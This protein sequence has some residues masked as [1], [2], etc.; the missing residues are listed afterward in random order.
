MFSRPANQCS[1]VFF[2]FQAIRSPIVSKK[3]YVGN[4]SF[5]TTEETLSDLF[6]EHGEVKSVK[7][8]TDQATGRSRGFGFVE[9]NTDEEAMSAIEN[10]DGKEAFGRTLRV[11]EAKERERGAGG[12]GGRGG[13]RGGDRGGRGGFGGGRGGFGG[14]GNRRRRDEE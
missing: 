7:I 14:G 1:L 5:Q 6:Q 8:I 4:L 3:L 10:L 13:D 2:Y 12:G 9:M 11:S